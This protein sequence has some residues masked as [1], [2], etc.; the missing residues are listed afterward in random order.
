MI[1]N[2]WGSRYKAATVFVLALLSSSS[3][4][5]AESGS[6]VRYVSHRTP[7]QGTQRELTADRPRVA[8]AAHANQAI[9][10][11]ANPWRLQAT[12]PGAVI[13]DLAF[14]TAQI[15]YVAAELGQVWKTS[16]GGENWTKIMDLGFPYYWY[17]V[18]AFNAMDVVISGFDN[19]AFTG[20]LRWSHDG[21]E[22]WSDDI[23]V[24]DQGWSMR[25]R[26]ADQ[27]NG[28]VMDLISLTA[29]NMAHYTTNGGATAPD[30]TS[31]VPDPNGGWF[32][33]Q[34]SLL[35]S[36]HAR[37]SGITYCD[38]ANSGAAWTCGPP[39]DSVFDGPVFFADEMNGWV[40]GGSISPDVAGWVHRT[41]DGGA[42]WSDRTL[43][44]PFPIREILFVSAQAGWAVGG[45]IYSNVGGIYFSNDGGQTWTSDFDSAGHELDACAH[46]EQHVWCAGYDASFSGAV[47]T[48]D[49]DITPVAEVSPTSL[50]FSVAAGE[51]A[52]APLTIAN[53]GAGALTFAIEEAAA[54]STPVRLH[55]TSS[56]AAGKTSRRAGRLLNSIGTSRIMGPRPASPWAPRNVDGSLSFV[57]DDGTY[58]DSVGLND[59]ASTESAGIW[60][61]RFAPPAGTGAFTID[62]VSIMWPQNTGGSLVGKDIN[63]VAYYDAD[64]DGDPSNAVRL[65]ADDILTIDSLDTFIDYAVN[66]AVPGDGDVY[67]GFENSYA[68]GGSSPI[69][70]PASIDEDSGSQGH[71]WVVGASTGDPDLDNLGNNDLAGTIDSFGLPGNWLIRGTGI[72]GGAGADCS[73]PTDVPWLSEAPANG[74]VAVGASLEVSVTVDAT[75]MNPG[76]YSALLCITTNDPANSLVQVPVSLTV[77]VGDRIFQDGFDGT[78]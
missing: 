51:T 9:G 10:T 67:I 78:P 25:V 46:V 70:F 11:V 23:V 34:F 54:A 63:L 57:L 39:V 18:Y 69:L 13:H 24:N 59:Q 40:G 61:N 26:F 58:E 41:T 76:D 47:Y 77:G 15:G 74:S 44:T 60:L 32:A 50:S 6:T 64:A 19:N 4:A 73:S 49:F 1:G 37:A 7:V 72:A 17:G 53:T 62:S 21:G 52:S 30:W 55:A 29:P 56:S 12:L 65:G 2:A 66:F 31:V 8:A 68:L 27:Q 5:A 28:L 3:A 36:G 45:N 33:N 48:L 75:G 42:T 38:S 20:I 35:A 43:D 71:S 14:P 16:D 22:T